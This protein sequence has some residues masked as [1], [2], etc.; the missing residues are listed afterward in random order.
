[1]SA[2]FHTHTFTCHTHHT[3]NHTNLSL[4]HT[5]TTTVAAQRLG[6]AEDEFHKVLVFEDAPNGV[7]AAKA[8]GMNVVAIPHPMNSR[9]LFEEADLILE[10]MEHF[11]PEEWCLPALLD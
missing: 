11:K 7:A 3:P 8:A 10:S 2:L 4:S 1:M 5:H 9:S 6:I